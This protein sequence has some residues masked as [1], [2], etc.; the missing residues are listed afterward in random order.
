MTA[1]VRERPDNRKTQEG[2]MNRM[3]MC[4]AVFALATT[5]AFG[6]PG[7]DAAASLAAREIKVTAKKYRFDPNP[8]TLKKGEHVKLIIT[9]LDHDHGF[10]LDA[11]NINQKIEK[12]TS[13]TVEFTADK[14]GT[15][16][17]QCSNFCGLGHSKMKGTLVVEEREKP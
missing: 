15:F 2:N 7:Q 16:P 4:L 13:A 9:A 12:G 11:F 5:A 6:A 8:I 14:A 17:F 10:K 3:K 1:T